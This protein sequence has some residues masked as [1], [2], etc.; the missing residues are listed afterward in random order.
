M[1][2]STKIEGYI[3]AFSLVVNFALLDALL[4]PK[5]T[6]LP[7]VSIDLRSD[8]LTKPS[9]AM[10]KAMFEAEVG[11][12]VYEEDPTVNK[13][14]RKAA[15]MF[16]KESSLFF[17]TGTMANIAA[18]MAWCSKRGSEVILG[19]QSHMYIYEQANLAQIGGISPRVVQN[20]ADGSLDIDRVQLAIRQSNV[21]YPVTEMIALENTH[22][23]CG[24]MIL[25]A[26]Y[27]ESVGALAKKAGVQL[28]MDG[29]RI[30]NAAAATRSSVAK[31][32]APAD[33]ISACLS[34]GLGAPA[35]SLLLGPAAFI[36][37]ARR[38]RK[39]LG[40]GM[41]QVG[42]LAAAGLQAIDDFEHGLLDGDHAKATK[43]AQG[44]AEISGLS[45]D[46]VD[47]NIVLVRL[48]AD[49]AKTDKFIRKLAEQG[50]KVLPFGAQT[51]RVVTHRD[52][53]DQDVPVVVAAFRAVAAKM[54]GAS[55]TAALVIPALGECC[56]Y[57]GAFFISRL[58]LILH[59]SSLLC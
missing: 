51:L 17:P 42:I 27:V 21:H 43:I 55:S 38:I 19:D 1:M 12:D 18:S 30:W 29:A 45:V 26:G 48:A 58:F 33:S 49:Q 47:T 11:D 5:L 52:I 8:T 2:F 4:L 53:T 24:G 13:L 50:V 36:A 16:G 10:R 31:L 54:W 57:F 22:N 40:G 7:K 56:Y 20:A 15:T 14:Q 39:A 35:G 41:R 34:K 9:S 25:P 59:V 23:V 28:H 37:R 44:L 6:G 3:F 32:S 46:K